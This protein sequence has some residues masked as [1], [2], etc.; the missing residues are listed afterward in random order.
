MNSKQRIIIVHNT[1]SHYPLMRDNSYYF[2][3][4]GVKHP[5][6]LFIS[7]PQKTMINFYNISDRDN[8]EYYEAI[9]VYKAGTPEELQLKPEDLNKKMDSG[10]AII[11]LG[12]QNIMPAF[13]AMLWKLEGTDFIINEIISIIPSFKDVPFSKMYFDVLKHSEYYQSHHILFEVEDPDFGDKTE[14]IQKLEHYFSHSFQL[15]Q[16]VKTVVPSPI[17]ESYENTLLMLLTQDRFHQFSKTKIS[18]LLIKIYSD[19]YDTE[20]DTYLMKGLLEHIPETV[21]LSGKWVPTQ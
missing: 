5:N 16:G 10:N 3:H 4:L 17:D 13:M 6:K 9:E 12:K 2:M 14:R 15:I 7:S 19:L 1:A 8:Q 20:K 21:E 18:Q 11:I